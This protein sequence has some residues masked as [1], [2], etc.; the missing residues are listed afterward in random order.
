[1]LKLILSDMRYNASQ[2]LAIIV[3]TFLVGAVLGIAE[4]IALESQAYLA[5]GWE[6]S[7]VRILVQTGGSIFLFS[8]LPVI[9]II[10]SLTHLLVQKLKYSYALW[11]VNGVSP[12]QIRAIFLIEL[13]LFTTVSGAMGA[14]SAFPFHTMVCSLFYTSNDLPICIDANLLVRSCIYTGW[15]TALLALVG[16]I[17]SSKLASRI[18]PISIFSYQN[19]TKTRWSLSRIIIVVAVLICS[20]CSVFPVIA[21][22]YE[23]ITW[24]FTLSYLL[25]FLF[26]LLAPWYF[27]KLLI[28]WSKVLKKRLLLNIARNNVRY[29]LSTSTSLELPI[30]ISY[31]LISVFFSDMKIFEV[32]FF[33]LGIKGDFNV[34]VQGLAI[35]LG[36]PIAVCLAGVM[37]CMIMALSQHKKIA[38]YLRICGFTDTELLREGFYEVTLHVLN[39]LIA[40]ILT[41]L[42]S[43]CLLSA[44]LGVCVF[45][46][47]FHTGLLV[48][49]G[50]WII[51]LITIAISL[52]LTQEC[53]RLDLLR[54]RD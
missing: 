52:T 14:L 40:G 22:R 7:Q 47:D 4:Q 27:P 49:S 29:S 48:V 38:A 18:S 11:A 31:C 12:R 21:H 24:G 6:F 35:I 34:P 23:S 54:T 46:P 43:N 45:N 30:F 37:G 15:C 2:W 41:T 32:F 50:F 44:L 20:L 17:K 42:I 5:R 33:S 26:S 53:D 19:E 10:L 25:V 8:S 36:F 51:L 28:F 1:M 16:S 39:A 3:F 9:P 13:A